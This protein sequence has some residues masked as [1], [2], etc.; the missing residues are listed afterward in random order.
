M[1]SDA[2]YLAKKLL[3]VPPG[4]EHNNNCGRDDDNLGCLCNKCME[5]R[6]GYSS[7]NNN[8]VLSREAWYLE[9]YQSWP[10]GVFTSLA[11]L[12][13]KWKTFRNVS[14]LLSLARS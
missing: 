9:I 10:F 13:P 4:F 2:L 11:V 1:D 14:R 7:N 6:L 8:E 12:M 3:V 5:E